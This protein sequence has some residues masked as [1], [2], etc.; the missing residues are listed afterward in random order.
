MPVGLRF[1][2][3][4]RKTAF[5]ITMAIEAKWNISLHVKTSVYIPSA[6]IGWNYVCTDIYILYLVYNY[7]CTHIAVKLACFDMQGDRPL[8][9]GRT[10]YLSSGT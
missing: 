10:K 4:Y 7:L 8:K 2:S 9:A 6:L 3:R 5:N 1:L